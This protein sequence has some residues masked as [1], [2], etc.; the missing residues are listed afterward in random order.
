MNALS[1]TLHQLLADNLGP[2]P[3][4]TALVDPDRS[5]TYAALAAEADLRPVE[6]GPSHPHRSVP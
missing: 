4:K 5:V 2:R 6:G 1:A 3:E